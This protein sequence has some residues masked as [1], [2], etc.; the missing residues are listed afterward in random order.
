MLALK[1]KYT[2]TRTGILLFASFDLYK[3]VNISLD[4]RSIVDE[5]LF[6]VE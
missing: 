6:F 5:K 2:L 3:I 1:L 4:G